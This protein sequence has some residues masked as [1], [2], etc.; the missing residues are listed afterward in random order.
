MD[1]TTKKLLQLLD[2]NDLELRTAAIRVITEVG[3]NS[4]PVIRALGRCLREPHERLQLA[5]LRGLARL[6]ARDVAPQV[7]PLVLSA[8]E[9]REQALAVVCALG[10]AV[11]TQLKNLYADADFHGKRSVISALARVGGRAAVEF[12]LQILPDEPFE[13]QKHLTMSLC[14]ALDRIPPAQQTV[15]QPLV[16]KM[17]QRKK[18][19]EQLETQ[20]TGI[21]MLG[22]FRGQALTAK[23]RKVLKGFVEKGNAPELRRY[24]LISLNRLIPE[25]RITPDY[26]RLMW[27]LLCDD[28]WDNVA[29]HAL[30][31][32]RRLEI[33]PKEVANLVDLLSRSPHFSVHIHVFERLR[34]TDRPD[35]AKAIIPFLADP[36]YRVR[37]AAEEALRHIPSGIDHLFEVLISSDDLEVTQRVNSILREFPQD[38]RAKYLDR[39][40]SR[41]LQLFDRND[42]HFKSFLEFIRG[43]DAGPLRQKLYQKARSLKVSRSR[44]R[45][46]RIRSLLQILWDNHLITPEGRYLFAVALIKESSKDLA[47]DS[48]RGDLGLQVLRAL[49]Y[50]DHKNLAKSLTSDRD[51]DADDL[52][53]LGFH[54]C[55]EGGDMGRFG[56]TLLDHVIRKYPKSR[57]AAP[58]QHKL[59]LQRPPASAQS[60]AGSAA[61]AGSSAGAAARKSA[62][63]V[64]AAA[65]GSASAKPPRPPLLTGGASPSAAKSGAGKPGAGKPRAGS[66][67]ARS[68]AA[69]PARGASKPARGAAKPKAAASS[70]AAAAARRPRSKGAAKSTRARGRIVSV[71]KGQK[72]R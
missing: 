55:E 42:P 27:K 20:V 62:P 68:K 3:L 58:A 22:H 43:V 9:L 7:V 37:E 67:A 23:A 51:L 46:S 35:V 29:Q 48:R 65:A 34:G 5:A 26:H 44:E 6:G 24:A 2:S 71:R 28:D 54:F 1:S 33:G 38:V 36:R 13:I 10:P 61:A 41:L 40:V 72:K 4:K 18:A 8:G 16:V 63:S 60:E 70:K 47:P 64:A 52:F 15:V 21:I 66:T 45:W 32:F 31:G 11:T 14:E 53:Y 59:S 50:D 30:N 39:A 19:R 56:E 69:A 25:A 17:L 57:F 12:L 49:V